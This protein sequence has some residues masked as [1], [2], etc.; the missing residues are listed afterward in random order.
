MTITSMPIRF[1]K[2]EKRMILIIQITLIMRRPIL[3][4]MMAIIR[5]RNKNLMVIG[6][7]V[8]LRRRR[9]NDSDQQGAAGSLAG[10]EKLEL[11]VE[12]FEWVYRGPEP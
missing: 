7:A 2:R 8:K 6:T 10:S 3:V 12:D 9:S 4:I 5:N 11:G 1:I